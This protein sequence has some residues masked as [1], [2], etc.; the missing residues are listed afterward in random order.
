[1]AVLAALP[2]PVLVADRRGIVLYV[3]MAAEA[4][5]EAPAERMCGL[6]LDEL[7]DGLG[8]LDRLIAD[9][10]VSMVS[11]ARV[12]F[13]AEVPL[14]GGKVKVEGTAQTFDLR[15]GTLLAMCLRHVPRA[16]ERGTRISAVG[17]GG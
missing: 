9:A 16:A 1:M 7:I 11:T 3:N 12:P 6:R 2:D 15:G 17:T 8:A 5:F 10:G 14:P 4:L 13:V